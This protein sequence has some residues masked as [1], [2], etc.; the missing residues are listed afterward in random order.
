MKDITIL[1]ETAK[2][3]AKGV[4]FSFEKGDNPIKM[5][6]KAVQ[7]IRAKYFEDIPYTAILG[8]DDSKLYL[9]VVPLDRYLKAHLSNIDNDLSLGEEMDL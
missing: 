6:S 1:Y 9:M 2:G 8:E 3:E 4:A 5:I 7:G